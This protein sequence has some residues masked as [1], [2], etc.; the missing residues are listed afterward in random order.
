MVVGQKVVCVDDV[1]PANIGLF[2]RELPKKDVTYV[3]RAVK[4]GVNFKGEAG[5]VCLYLIGLTNPTSS[6][7]PYPERGF[8]S[9]RFRP[10]NEKEDTEELLNVRTDE[11]E[12]ALPI[13]P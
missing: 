12:P 10:L 4:I 7:P 5:E 11:L 2:Y 13:H 6:T 9:E 3:I 8:N 1:F